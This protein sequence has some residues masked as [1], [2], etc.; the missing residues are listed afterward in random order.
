MRV[1]GET[2]VNAKLG[3]S[4]VPKYLIGHLHHHISYLFECEIVEVLAE[5]WRLFSQAVIVP[6]YRWMNST[7]R[8]GTRGDPESYRLDWEFWL[9]LLLRW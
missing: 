4:Q 2:T 6:T 3:V 9:P 5:P 8:S 7:Y 1:T